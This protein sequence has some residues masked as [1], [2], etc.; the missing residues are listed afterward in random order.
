MTGL[1]HTL[2]KGR[3]PALSAARLD[4]AAAIAAL[5]AESFR[6][7][8]GEDEIGALLADR[9]VVGHR[10]MARDTMA[11]FVLSRSTLDEAEILSLA[12]AP[13]WRGRRLSRRLLDYHLRAL[14][15]RAVRTVFLEVDEHNAPA[16]ALY[17]GAGFRQVGQRL[18]YYAGAGQALI[19][20]RDL[21]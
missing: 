8:W 14:A 3:Q 13:A 2:W 11:G 19:M 4:D 5:H 20:R 21:R 7:G 10:A 9:S 1:L 6:R 12:V 15:G 17:T 16:R 18:G